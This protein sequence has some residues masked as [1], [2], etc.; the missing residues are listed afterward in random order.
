[1]TVSVQ[2]SCT[3]DLSS[4]GSCNMVQYSQDL[5]D[6][7]QNFHAV[8]GVEDSEVGQLGSSVTLADFCPYIQ[9]GIGMTTSR[10]IERTTSHHDV[11]EFTWRGGG[12]G[13][14]G[15]GTRCDNADNAP[16]HD[17]NYALESYG[18]SS[19]CF[20]QVRGERRDSWPQL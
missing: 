1:M 12:E 13:A 4:V 6:I 20:R 14:E 3:A 8:A 9:V 16:Q 17:N 2:T 11:Q 10:Y 19:R 7:Y 18:G 15:R 5:P